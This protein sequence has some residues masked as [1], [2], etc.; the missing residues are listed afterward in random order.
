MP[1]KKTAK[2][3]TTSKRARPEPVIVG[4][5]EWVDLPDCGVIGVKAKI[6]TGARTSALHAIGLVE[7]DGGTRVRFDIRPRQR[8]SIGMTT[9]ECDVFD[10]RRIRSSNGRTEIR[11]V[12][13]TTLRLAGV[14]KMIELT[15]TNRD[16]MGFRMLIGRQAL[17]RHFLID[18]TTSFRG[19]GAP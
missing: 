2:K 16:E 7:L 17:R 13:L 10:R 15:L 6:D 11:P 5:R 8:S 1:L 3:K 12:I 18:P 19:G 14:T 4:W 9:V